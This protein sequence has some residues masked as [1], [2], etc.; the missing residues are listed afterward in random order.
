MALDADGNAYV[1]ECDNRRVSKFGPDGTFLGS[2][3]HDFLCLAGITV[4]QEHGIVYVSD[5]DQQRI[6]VFDTEG[7][8]LTMWGEA[9]NGEGQF[10]APT[11]VALDGRGHVY[12]TDIVS[13]K[14]SEFALLP[15][16]WPEGTPV[17]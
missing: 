1:S 11:V 12:V 16:L 2:W 3:D 8:F 10:T 17:A 5:A 4:D 14:I 9:G 15:P 7:N 13:G 6:Q